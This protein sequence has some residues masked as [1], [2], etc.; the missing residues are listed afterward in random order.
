MAWGLEIAQHSQITRSVIDIKTH[1][2]PWLISYILYDLNRFRTH[3]DKYGCA[4]KLCNRIN[5]GHMPSCLTAEEVTAWM[6]NYHLQFYVDTINYPC[7]EVSVGLPDICG[8]RPVSGLRDITSNWPNSQIPEYTC[9][10]SQSAPW[11]LWDMESVHSGIYETGLLAVFVGV[12]LHRA[13]GAWRYAI[14]VVQADRE[15]V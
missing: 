4:V 7:L 12:Y 5:L 9:S 14:W 13:N 1:S 3:V 11:A 10:I 2:Q 15:R 8:I 6:S